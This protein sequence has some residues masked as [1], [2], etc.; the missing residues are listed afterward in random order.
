MYVQR[1]K[2]LKDRRQYLNLSIDK[3]SFMIGVADNVVG[4]WERGEVIPNMH[5][6]EAW[7]NALDLTVI[8]SAENTPV[9][10]YEPQENFIREIKQQFREVNYNYE[11]ENFKDWYRSSGTRS[12][13]WNSLFRMWCRR[14]T[15][16]NGRSTASNQKDSQI[17]SSVHDRLNA[18][19]NLRNKTS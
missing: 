9:D 8:L 7:C 5:N 15:N 16:F 2:Q 19:Q 13:D 10:D 17:I 3:L 6:F 1:L 14:S 12:A 4:R 18:V 11:Y